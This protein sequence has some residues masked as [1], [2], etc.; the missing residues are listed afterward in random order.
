MM[1]AALIGFPMGGSLASTSSRHG[2]EPRLSS[3]DCHS[4]RRVDDSTTATVRRVLVV[5]AMTAPLF[6]ACSTIMP[7]RR[8]D[9][10]T[11]YGI[12]R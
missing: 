12:N 5:F 10:N 1:K 4:R 8:D 3:S 11:D 6:R 2:G 9:V 7:I